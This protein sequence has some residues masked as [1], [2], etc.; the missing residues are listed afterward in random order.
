RRAAANG[1]QGS[2]DAQQAL[3]NLQDARRL[4]DQEKNGRGTRD[5]SDAMRQAQQLADQEKKVQDAVQQLAQA[6][7]S[8]AGTNGQQQQQLRQQIAD[9]KGAM[10]DRATSLKSQL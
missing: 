8:G 4:L 10:A 6:G 9:Q 7:A 1:Q 2:G 5:L 3:N